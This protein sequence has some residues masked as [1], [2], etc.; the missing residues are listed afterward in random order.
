MEIQGACG[1]VWEQRWKRA[2]AERAA[3]EV[4]SFQA[5]EEVS[6]ASTVV[7][8]GAHQGRPPTAKVAGQ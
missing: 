4:D 6:W 5:S 7:E 3:E 2:D 8:E 1:I